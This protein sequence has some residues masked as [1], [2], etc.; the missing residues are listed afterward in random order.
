MEDEFDKISALAAPPG[1][2][3]TD[4]PGKWA[5]ERPPQYANPDEA[6]DFVLDKLE[7][8]ARREDIMRLL[9]AGISIQELVAQIAFKGF[10]KG[11]YTPDVAEL[12]KPSIAIYLYREA[13]EEGFEPRLMVDPDEEEGVMKGDV[14]DE[15]FFTIMQER[16][17][18]LFKA[19]NEMINYQER[20]EVDTI[21]ESKRASRNQK[22][23]MVPNAAQESFLTM[24][25]M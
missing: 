20:M 7:Q 12:I 16:N 21:A 9:V 10:M 19:M 2:S 6:L 18:E 4:E 14:D 17:P 25:E 15:S 5:W 3:L 1:H 8:P 11:F 23:T 22:E 13:L 24:G